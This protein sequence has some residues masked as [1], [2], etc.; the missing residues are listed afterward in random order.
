MRRP[1]GESLNTAEGPA[2]TELPLGKVVS[3]AP[4]SLSIPN[5]HGLYE[6]EK[7][8]TCGLH[9]ASSMETAS[10]VRIACESGKHR[11]YSMP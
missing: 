7:R 1:P 2:E 6:S 8:Q 10:P 3:E 9:C 4:G 11:V 5:G